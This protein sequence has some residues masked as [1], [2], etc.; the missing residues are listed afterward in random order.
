MD[1]RGKEKMHHALFGSCGMDASWAAAHALQRISR[2][3]ASCAT[4]RQL[5]Q[6]RLS[7]GLG[8]RSVSV[9]ARCGVSP[10]GRQVLPG[11]PRPWR[12]AGALSSTEPIARAA[13]A[14][15]QTRLAR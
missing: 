13:A 5:A 1:V 14:V 2:L 7:V 11:Q 6:R 15:A 4:R 3:L 8:L 12:A 10:G 9:S